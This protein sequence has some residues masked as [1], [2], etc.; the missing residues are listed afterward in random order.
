MSEIAHLEL[1]TLIALQFSTM[2]LMK[3]ADGPVLRTLY[4]I[5]NLAAFGGV[6]YVLI[7]GRPL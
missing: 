2:A 6:V 5:Y 7:T 1:G 3:L 4:C